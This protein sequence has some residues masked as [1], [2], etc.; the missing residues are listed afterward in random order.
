[1]HLLLLIILVTSALSCCYYPSWLLCC[2]LLC[3][4]PKKKRYGWPVL[5]WDQK[6]CKQILLKFANLNETSLINLVKNNFLHLTLLLLTKLL[7]QHTYLFL[8]Y[9]AIAIIMPSEIST[10]SFLS[11]C[12]SFKTLSFI[13]PL[14]LGNKY[15]FF[16]FTLLLLLTHYWNC[17]IIIKASGITNS[18]QYYNQYIE[19]FTLRCLG[20]EWIK[21][22]CIWFGTAA[23]MYEPIAIWQRRHSST[24][25]IF[26]SL[27]LENTALT[28]M[29]LGTLILHSTHPLW[30]FVPWRIYHS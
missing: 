10:S 28:S 13:L 2:C 12:C 22:I 29:P 18:L 7:R 20:P 19:L 17:N 9:I 6:T 11:L 23:V 8:L 1:M 4:C 5:R 24:S 26:F 16:H 15:I 3:H 14:L 21:T 30:R 27:T 25:S